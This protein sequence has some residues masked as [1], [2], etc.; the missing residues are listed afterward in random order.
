MSSCH[1]A[2]HPW[3]KMPEELPAPVSEEVCDIVVLGAGLSG[4]TAADAAAASGAS[5]IVVEKFASYT[6]HGIDIGAV[7][8]SVQKAHGVTIDKAL[9][10][11]LIYDW[12]QQQAN[13]HLIRT[14]TERSGAVLDRYIRMASDYGLKVSLNDEMTARADW[15]ILEDKF[16]QFQT[17]HLFE[18]TDDCPFKK[19][20]WNAEYLI[21]MIIASAKASGAQFRYRTTARRLV[22]EGE[23]V[24][25]VLVEDT[26]G[27]KK[28][29]A[30]KGVII[31]T[32]GITDNKEMLRC[33]WPAALRVDKCESFPVG[34]NMGD[35]LL[36]GVWAGAAITRCQ[37]APII[38]PV[39]F[40]ALNPGMNTSWLTVNRDGQRFSNEMA[41]EPMVTNARLNA[42]GNVAWAIWDGDYKAHVEKQEPLKAQKLLE[43][44]EE[45]VAR[46]VASGDYIMADTLPQ[47]AEKINIP[48]AALVK[49][50]ERYNGWC[51]SGCDEDFGVPERF[52]SPVRRGPF[53]AHKITAW[54]LNVPHGL[55]VDQNSQVLTEDDAPIGGLFAVGNAQGDFLAN[56]Y[57]VTLPGSGNGRGICF[58]WLVGEALAKGTVFGG[59][60]AVKES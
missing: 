6:A 37:P 47:L 58:G 46:D 14:Y 53:Y 12:G 39:N 29:T 49:T 59:Y 38:H 1:N 52:L 11:R 36:M 50:A 35:G 13:Y 45:R 54:L 17:A 23:A 60:D 41:W 27:I 16:K 44:I 33:F 34:A 43:G 56:S 31:A 5:V 25:G 2:V 19:S 55:H 15:N 42:P 26:A 20:K 4:C 40:T 10:A 18:R 9:A 28:I 22:R 32:G 7:G 24:T 8:T 3:L 51:D 48:T 30:R 21:Q 57:P